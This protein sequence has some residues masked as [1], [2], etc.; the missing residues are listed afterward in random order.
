VE[1]RK[2]EQ[3]HAQDQGSGNWP[4]RQTALKPQRAA[5]VRCVRVRRTTLQR[6]RS[7]AI[8]SCGA[9]VHVPEPRG[10]HVLGARSTT[11]NKET[12]RRTGQNAGLHQAHF[13]PL[14]W[15]NPKPADRNPKALRN[16]KSSAGVA[17]TKAS[18]PP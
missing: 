17:R 7:R 8:R 2:R 6:F 9:S 5:Q 13:E 10:G 4:L 18:A 15:A 3:Q 16:S 11:S 12:H 1:D 14:G